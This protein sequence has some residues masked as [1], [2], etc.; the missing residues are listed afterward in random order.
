[1]KRLRIALP[2]LWAAVAMVLIASSL[3]MGAGCRADFHKQEKATHWTKAPLPSGD[4]RV[5]EATEDELC[6]LT[7]VG[8]SLAAEIVRERTENG[9]FYYPEDLLCVKGIG[10]GKLRRM[11]DQLNMSE[12]D[13]EAK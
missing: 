6:A 12:A 2:I 7:G 13:R 9:S 1:M 11:L 10:R 5:N 4:V 8:P 3:S